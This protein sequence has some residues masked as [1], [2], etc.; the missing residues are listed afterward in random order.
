MHTT[1]FMRQKNWLN[2]EWS[3]LCWWVPRSKRL[4]PAL[5]AWIQDIAHCQQCKGRRP[6]DW[7]ACNTSN[8]AVQT[9]STECP[10]SEGVGYI[11][12]PIVCREYVSQGSSVTFTS[13]VIGIGINIFKANYSAH[14][15]SLGSFSIARYYLSK[16]SVPFLWPDAKQKWI[17]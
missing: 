12:S 14:H 10:Q 17:W 11:R 5:C 7:S 9:S 15:L 2:A 4:L 6:V 16:Y 13:D 3:R 1:G 8:F